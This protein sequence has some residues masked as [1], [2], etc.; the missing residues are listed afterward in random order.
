MEE[1]QKTQR[2]QLEVNLAELEKS[3]REKLAMILSKAKVECDEKLNIL[4]ESTDKQ[5]AECE[6][7]VKDAKDIYFSTLEVLQNL[8]DSKD[9]TQ[10]MIEISASERSDIDFLLN[11]VVEK[12][13]KPD[14]LYKLIWSEYIQK[15]TNRML[16]YI[17]PSKDCSGIYK[18]TNI[19]NGKCYIGRSTSVRKRLTDHIKSAIGIS[20]IADQ[21]IH[22]VMR[23]EGIWNFRF[24][25]IEAC[26][27]SDLGSREKYYIDFFNSS[28]QRYGYNAV[29]GSEY[30]E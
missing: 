8:K 15:P 27:K 3:E 17:L 24:E 26:E 13:R 6:K 23:K 10:A 16:D 19:N 1:L 12:I 14:V 21:H 28:N 11:T 29:G 30:K 20:T 22:E 5:I 18:I 4:L 25:L 9:D 2:E 7:K